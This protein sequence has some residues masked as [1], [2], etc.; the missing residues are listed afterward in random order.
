ME[1]KVVQHVPRINFIKILKLKKKIFFPGSQLLSDFQ[2]F[3]GESRDLKTVYHTL[4]SFKIIDSSRQVVFGTLDMRHNPHPADNKQK[5]TYGESD[6]EA[7][8]DILLHV[9]VTK[10]GQNEEIKDQ[11]NKG[12]TNHKDHLA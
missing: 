11:S 2:T 5:V 4:Y 8:D 1:T 9:L 3:F 10:Y 6:V 7:L 12:N